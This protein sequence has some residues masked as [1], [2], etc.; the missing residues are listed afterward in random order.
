MSN[1]PT[2]GELSIV[3]RMPETAGG[4]SGGG[5]DGPV[6][7]I[8]EGSITSDPK[9]GNNRSQVMLATAIQATKTI[10]MQAVNASISNIGVATG[11][12]YR[13]RK[14]QTAMQMGQNIVNLA[15]SAIDPVTFG[16]TIASMAISYG[17]ELYQQQKERE[18]ENYKSQ[19]YAK[20]LGYTV[21]RK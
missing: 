11:D 17:T 16:I 13:Q 18:F 20:R 4:D 1:I 12:Y 21:A 14:A 6:N 9:K 15:V 10:G 5:G 8:D 3:I 19:Q 2:T 7:P